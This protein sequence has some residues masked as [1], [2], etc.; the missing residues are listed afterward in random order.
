MKSPK[1]LIVIVGMIVA[2]LAVQSAGEKAKRLKQVVPRVAPHV[3]PQPYCPDCPGGVCPVPQQYRELEAYFQ[4][5]AEPA[6]DLAPKFRQR[7]WTQG[8]QGSC[9]HATTVMLLRWQGQYSIAESWKQAYGGGDNPIAHERKLKEVGLRYVM[10]DDGDERLLDW[11]I[12]TRR[13][14]GVSWPSRHFVALVGRDGD[15]AIILDNNRVGKYTYR[16]WSEFVSEWK[17]C[18]GWAVAFLYEVP[19]PVPTLK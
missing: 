7:N 17:S 1:F 10:T 15:T 3:V 19:P 5:L 13:G 2:A 6:V 4:S 18:G 14:C 12:A 9:V 16:P 11:A 8:G